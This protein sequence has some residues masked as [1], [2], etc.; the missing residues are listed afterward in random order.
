MR[1]WF[2][3]CDHFLRLFMHV[4]LIIPLLSLSSSVS[5]CTHNI[6]LAR[7]YHDIFI[8][9]FS[10]KGVIDRIEIDMHY[11]RRHTRY[12]R[13]WFST[14]LL[15][16]IF[17]PIKW[18]TI[19]TN[20]CFTFISFPFTLSSAKALRYFRSISLPSLIV[21]YDTRYGVILN[22]FTFHASNNITILRMILLFY[23]F[24]PTHFHFTF[25]MIYL[26][27][28]EIC[29]LTRQYHNASYFMT[30]YSSSK[31]KHLPH[32]E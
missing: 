25:F 29:I 32:S 1:D 5:K 14:L 27:N 7:H 19:H 10:A 13:D 17:S 28:S 24:T 12:L 16:M 22:G 30:L 4:V 8:I 20:T 23:H 2:S 9:F 11:F 26:Y 31:S 6:L 15:S 18:V 3:V 21:A